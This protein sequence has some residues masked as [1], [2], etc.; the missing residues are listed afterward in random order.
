MLTHDFP[1]DIVDRQDVHEV[2]FLCN[3]AEQAELDV[4]YTAEMPDFL[5]VSCMIRTKYNIRTLAEVEL[6]V[7]RLH[8]HVQSASSVTIILPRIRR[9]IPTGWR[10]RSIVDSARPIHCTRKQN[11]QSNELG[12]TQWQIQLSQK[13][14][15]KA[16]GK[17]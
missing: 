13:Q 16:S 10:L 4:M 1:Y 6:C 11:N 5:I 15:R 17:V 14:R 2:F 12:G 8:W 9:L 3:S 7:Q